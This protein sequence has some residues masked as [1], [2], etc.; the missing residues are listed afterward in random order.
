MQNKT[1]LKI[2]A[3][4]LLEMLLHLQGYSVHITKGGH[5]YQAWVIT[6]DSLSKLI[7]DYILEFEPETTRLL[8]P[9]EITSLRQF[10]DVWNFQ[11]YS[12]DIVKNN[13]VI[14]QKVIKRIWT[15]LKLVRLLEHYGPGIENE[16]GIQSISLESS[17]SITLET[18]TIILNYQQ[19]DT[20][21]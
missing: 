19:Y 5:Q 17:Y 18:I 7:N 6:E 3:K 1:K 21:D 10:L 14:K 15:H 12:A 2:S 4:H 20:N 8:G 11:E 13:L 9:P 16:F